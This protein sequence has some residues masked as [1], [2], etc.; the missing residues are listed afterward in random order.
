M[1][2]SRK[3]KR[4]APSQSARLAAREG[5]A[6]V[7]G[8]AVPNW[9]REQLRA[10]LEY[11]PD[12][13]FVSDAAGRALDVNVRGYTM[14]GYD[15]PSEVIGRYLQDFIA[16]DE[17]A[18]EAQAL[19]ALTKGQPVV[20]EWHLK[21]KDGT[22]LSVDINATR[23]PDG[24]LLGFVRDMSARNRLQALVSLQTSMLDQTLDAIFV[25]ELGGTIISWNRGAE[26]LYGYA[27]PEAVGRVRHE[28]VRTEHTTGSMQQFEATLL[29]DGHWSGELTHTT[30]DGRTIVVDSRHQVLRQPD[31]KLYVLEINRDITDRKRLEDDLA[32]RAGQLEA[33]FDAML[34]GVLVYDA[35]GRIVDANEAARKML[36]YDAHPEIFQTPATVRAEAYG[37]AG[38]DGQRI[39]VDELPINRLLRG[40]VLVGARAQDCI[41]RALDGRELL[42]NVTGSPIRGADGSIVGAVILV[43]D[44]AR[45]RALERRTQTAL[46]AL[47]AMADALV[48][49]TDGSQEEQPGDPQGNA[50]AR[51]LAE[52]TCSVL[53]CKRV[54]ITA[55]ESETL[56]QRPVA[57]VGL[58]PEQEQGWRAEQ[59]AH[60]TRYGEGAD[61]A[62][63]AR[64]EAGEALVLDMTQPPYDQLPNPYGIT[65]SLFAPM[66]AGSGIVGILSLDYAG[67]R[68]EFAA[69]EMALAEAVALLCAQ[70]IER[71]RLLREREAA[72][73]NELSLL[74]LTERMDD[75]LSMA[76]HDLKSPAT[77][78]KLSIQVAT[79]RMQRLAD[80][81][82]GAP[83]SIPLE[84][85][86]PRVRELELAL[87]KA[88]AGL[89]RLL[90]MVDRLLD[91]SRARTGK[92]K[93]ETVPMDLAEVV[94]AAVEEQQTLAPER[95]IRLRVPAEPARVRADPDRIGQVVTNYLTNALRYAPPDS[96]VDVLLTVA[97]DVARVAVRDA[98]PGISAADQDSVW[99]R[100]EQAHGS[101]RNRGTESGLGLGLYICRSIIEQHDGQVGVESVPG[102]GAEFWFTL[103]LL[104]EDEGAS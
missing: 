34:E 37:L 66:R 100:F 103:P 93:L 32:A 52:L 30:R 9:D 58:T 78:S 50:V 33:T 38:A 31:G 76:A 46:S 65:T 36:D 28:L 85:I 43:R 83:A 81:F 13:V 12:G 47:L 42:L 51:R 56:L 77:G 4:N 3:S 20:G 91:V 63:L 49:P 17:K 90:R 5:G 26:L 6:H 72:R 88:E 89:N 2:Q 59:E 19:Q 57:V 41:V 86:A 62:L 69:S 87:Q 21:R 14:L 22:Y 7:P 44:V 27:A 40:T 16:P 98:G 25:W 39:P 45:Q 95:V 18:A 8:A 84:S 97:A 104:T 61:P 68:H 92:L 99:D 74:A 64:F 1:G 80:E 29:R 82:D 48:G 101:S 55:V 11:A 15:S 71:D 54:G 94:R 60:P 67:E 35:A 10:M 53:G 73:A 96:P 79:R 75:F 70:V 24:T 23:L 102:Q